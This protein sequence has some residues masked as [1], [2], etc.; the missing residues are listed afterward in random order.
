M[1]GLLIRDGWRGASISGLSSA[2]QYAG[3]AWA[4]KRSTIF[5]KY[6]AEL[7]WG[8]RGN[9]PGTW[10]GAMVPRDAKEVNLNDR[11]DSIGC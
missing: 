1:E 6:G 3:I 8:A 2:S 9:K 7:E 10:R 5:D 11:T 4:R